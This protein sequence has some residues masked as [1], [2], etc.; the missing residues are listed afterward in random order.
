MSQL[1][2]KYGRCGPALFPEVWELLKMF[3]VIT[4]D[5]LQEQGLPP[6]SQLKIMGAICSHFLLAIRSGII[7]DYK[8]TS[9]RKK[10]LYPTS[11][12][13]SRVAEFAKATA[14]RTP[15]ISHLPGISRTIRDRFEEDNDTSTIGPIQW[16]SRGPRPI[17]RRL[18]K[19]SG[20]IR[21]R[22]QRLAITTGV[23]DLIRRSLECPGQE[24]SQFSDIRFSSKST[25]KT[26]ENSNFDRK[27]PTKYPH[28][29]GTF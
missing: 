10:L 27:D 16:N 22:M 2:Q 18:S 11:K 12:I 4:N 24:D 9:Q 29:N 28:T 19:E 13:A 20:K 5:R 23:W 17:D 25:E 15:T 3:T 21:G 26:G 8:E 6:V 7:D 14:P 1:K